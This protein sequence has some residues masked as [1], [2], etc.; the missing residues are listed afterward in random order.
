MNVTISILLLQFLNTINLNV[1]HVL[2]RQ[3]VSYGKLRKKRKH[4]PFGEQEE[5]TTLPSK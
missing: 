2:E 1:M 5:N 4:S 3:H